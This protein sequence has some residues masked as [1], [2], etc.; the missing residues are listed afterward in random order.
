MRQVA[1]PATDDRLLWDIWM[2]AFQFSALALADD[3]GLFS[4][5]ESQP[6]TADEIAA[7]LSLSPISA[8]ALLGVLTSLG[9]LARHTGTFSLTQVSRTFLLPN[10]PYYW[11]SALRVFRN[12]PVSFSA[13]RKALLEDQAADT[14]P[15]DPTEDMNEATAFTP[16]MHSLSFPAAMALAQRD[17]FDGVRRLLD[18]GGDRRATASPWPC[19]ILKCA[20]RCWKPLTSARRRSDSS[21]LMGWQTVSTACP[22]ICSA[23][24]GRP[25]TMPTSWRTSG[26]GRVETSAWNWHAAAGGP[27]RQEGASIYTRCSWLMAK[28]ARRPRRCF[29][30]R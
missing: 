27:C 28:T 20:A 12:M 5:L 16:A 8:E 3:L 13:L 23:R 9:L 19:G 21:P 14:P 11:G 4:V 15:D 1:L 24:H 2:S 6:A 29:R 30:W 22:P 17:E 18:V 25:A 10:S 26:T 7:R